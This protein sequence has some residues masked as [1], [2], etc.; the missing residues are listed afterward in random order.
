MCHREGGRR[1][2]HPAER[3]RGLPVNESGG[4]W[5]ALGNVMQFAELLQR[6]VPRPGPASYLTTNIYSSFELMVNAHGRSPTS[7]FLLCSLLSDA[8]GFPQA[9]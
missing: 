5:A 3:A 6:E 2:P 4:R 8:L 7:S 1:P 9:A